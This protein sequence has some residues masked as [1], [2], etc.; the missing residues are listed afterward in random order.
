MTAAKFIDNGVLTE[1]FFRHFKS[2]TARNLHGEA[3]QEAAQVF[4]LTDL[5]DEFARI[6]R[7]RVRIGHLP[8]DLYQQRYNAYAKL[9]QHAKRS[10]S[11]AQF[12]RFYMCF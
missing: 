5:R 3:Y 12:N 7:E 1:A 4:G 6:E 11:E 9:M 10:L 8:H 2:L